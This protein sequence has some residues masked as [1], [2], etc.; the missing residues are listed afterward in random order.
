MI[1]DEINQLGIDRHQVR[2]FDVKRETALNN[3]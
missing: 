2:R 1:L 3:K